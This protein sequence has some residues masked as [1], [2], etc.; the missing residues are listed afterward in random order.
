MVKMTMPHECR[1][2]RGK[3]ESE[4]GVANKTTYC[5]GFKVRQEW[6]I[7][8]VEAVCLPT[9]QRN[10]CESPDELFRYVD[11]SI[12][13]R[14]TKSILAPLVLRGAEAPSRARKEI[15]S[16]DVLVSTVRPNLN[17]VCLVPDSL[18]GQIASTGF[19]VLRGNARKVKNR[20]LF[21]YTITPDFIQYLT[22]RT[23]G[24][25]YPALSDS[26]VKS[27]LLPLPPLP[28]Q[29]RIVRLLDAA[30]ELR[31]LRAAADRRTADLIPALFYDMFGDPNVALHPVPELAIV[32]EVVSGVA[33]GRQFNGRHTVT[34]PYLR[35]ANVQAGHLDLTEI[36]TIE[37]LPSEVEELALKRGDV[38]LTEG[39][40]FDK[41][42]RGAL[43]EADMPDC[44]HQNHI[45]RV[46]VE[47]TK[48][49]PI[50]F[51]SLLQTPFAKAYFLSCSKKTTNLASINMTQLRRLPVPVPPLI[52]Q[53]Q[54]AARVAEIRA[55]ETQQAVSRRRLDDLFQSMLHRAFRGEL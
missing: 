10:P 44:I 29:E 34:V 19:C 46:R 35:V 53:R 6:P 4:T 48:L 26:I 28:E 47:K 7:V 14:E 39:G 30:E 51:A 23:S 33:K 31:R 25:S 15:R 16:G 42:G 36:K 13:D 27:A 49:L 37:A 22:E 11:I 5:R 9:S 54:F 38:L 24:A 21:Y 17:S 2:R 32:A 1:N 55:L 8:P 45:F 43:W 18:D 52:E 3:P 40:D 41:L 12:V 50:Y 20:F